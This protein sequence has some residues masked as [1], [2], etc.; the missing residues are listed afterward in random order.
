MYCRNGKAE[1]L[2][3]RYQ[4]QLLTVEVVSLGYTVSCK[5]YSIVYHS[6]KWGKWGLVY[7]SVKA[8]MIRIKIG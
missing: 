5:I 3:D 7:V 1:R 8:P 4:L 6:R 2:L